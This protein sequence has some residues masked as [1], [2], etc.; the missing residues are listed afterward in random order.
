[1]SDRKPISLQALLNT[2]RKLEDE[3]VVVGH[4]YSAAPP[5]FS[6]PRPL[7]EELKSMMD[8]YDI[9]NIVAGRESGDRRSTSYPCGWSRTDS[10]LIYVSRQPSWFAQ[11]AQTFPTPGAY[12]FTYGYASNWTVA[13]PDEDSEEE[14][15]RRLFEFENLIDRVSEEPAVKLDNPNSASHPSPDYVGTLTGWRAWVV[16]D[17]MLGSVGTKI[18]WKP[19]QIIPANCMAD[20]VHSA[21]R[22]DCTCGY[23]SFKSFDFNEEGSS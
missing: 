15:K 19:R 22:M 5:S 20:E 6:T 14:R 13:S 21:P 9:S 16:N 3:R 17:R 12:T 23:W 7:A 2:L 4:G 1:M 8:R 11:L 10:G 18:Y